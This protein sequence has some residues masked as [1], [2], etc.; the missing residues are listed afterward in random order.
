MD[1]DRKP[2]EPEFPYALGDRVWLDA[3]RDG[4]QGSSETSITGA[5]VSL[6]AGDGSLLATTTTDANGAYRLT[7]L[8]GTY[9][10]D[11]NYPAN[12]VT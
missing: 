3:N 6:R 10:V 1:A 5:I 9:T 11:I 4:I 2:A 8:P 7:S 12:Y